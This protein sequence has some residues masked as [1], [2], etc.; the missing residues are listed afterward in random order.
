M[1]I[2]LNPYQNPIPVDI[3]TASAGG[4]NFTSVFKSA[5]SAS[6][7]LAYGQF[8]QGDSAFATF[9]LALPA[10]SAVGAGLNTIVVLNDTTFGG[11][12]F[13]NL[14]P[15]GGDT[16]NAVP[17]ALGD[18]V[19]LISDGVSNWTAAYSSN[20]NAMQFATLAGFPAAATFPGRF[21]ID[22][23]DGALY[24]SFGGTWNIIVA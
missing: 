22:Q 13:I 21:A 7:Q 12:N 19:Y 8:V 16:L 24:F 10:A 6:L 2:K 3:P 18:W 20:G 11:T 14:T 9:S 17:L 1:L 4:G 15:F 23:S 5:H